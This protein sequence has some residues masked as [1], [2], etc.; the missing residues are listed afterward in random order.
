[1][2]TIVFTIAFAMMTVVA[3][4][5]NNQQAKA[6]NK[7]QTETKVQTRKGPNF[8]DKN[9]N[10]ICDNYEQGTR[11]ARGQKRNAKS[12]GRNFVDKNKDGICDN[13]QTGNCQGQCRGNRTVSTK[14]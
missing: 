14:K 10:G 12:G 7:A 3:F 4:G 6:A 9:K 2:R 1:M 13:Y 5:Q 8:V 11:P